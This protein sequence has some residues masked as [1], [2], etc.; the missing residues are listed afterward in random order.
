MILYPDAP[1]NLPLLRANIDVNNFELLEE[2]K[3]V[4]QK[5]LDSIISRPYLSSSLPF[6]R[7]I[8]PFDDV[9]K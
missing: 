2:R 9:K 6:E 4:L 3:S 7:F 5:F 1:I 8:D